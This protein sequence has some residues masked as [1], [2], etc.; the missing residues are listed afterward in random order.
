MSRFFK[1]FAI[2]SGYCVI[3]IF[4]VI[5]LA[6]T[7]SFF[8]INSEHCSQMIQEQ[9]N[10]RIPGTMVWKKLNISF[11]KGKLTIDG[12]QL[13]LDGKEIAGVDKLDIL[14][15]PSG[16]ARGEIVVEHF[17]IESPRAEIFISQDQKINILG[18]F[19]ESV[20]S[21]KEPQPESDVMKNIHFNVIV[22][23]LNIK[24]GR[25]TYHSE[26]DAVK[27]TL[28]NLAVTGKAN[29]FEKTA[30]ISISTGDI[31]FEQSGGVKSKLE[32]VAM[33]GHFLVDSISG[34][35]LV[36]DSEA[37]DIVIKGEATNLLPSD[38]ILSSENPPFSPD[39]DFTLDAN[40]VS[41]EIVRMLSLEHDIGGGISIHTEI[42]GSI[43]DP[44]LLCTIEYP[45][46]TL[47]GR[48]IE[49]F[50]FKGVMEKR[51]IVISS[52]EIDHPHAKL[53]ADGKVSLVKAF[54]QGFLGT[55]TG[56][57]ASTTPISAD[58]DK[59]PS[60][61]SVKEPSSSS[62]KHPSVKHPS[63]D[64]ADISWDFSIAGSDIEPGII[65][66]SEGIK[67]IGGKCGFTAK[68][69]GNMNNPEAHLDFQADGATYEGYPA[70]DT[71]L[72]V[73]LVDGVVNI[74]N[75]DISS[76]G[77]NVQ[78]KGSVAV[79]EKEQN[80]SFGKYVPM[81][82]PLLNLTAVPGEAFDISIILKELGRLGLLDEQNIE[83]KV[84]FKT[85]LK[86]TLDNLIAKVDL[87]A[88]NIKYEAEKIDKVDLKAE[89]R[90]KKLTIPSLDVT[91]AE[92]NNLNANG[93]LDENKR[94]NVVLASKG[95]DLL[96]I[97]AV[98]KTDMLKGVAICSVSASGTFD[99]PEING[100]IS[101]KSLEVMDKPFEDFTAY[102][103]LKNRKAR[104]AG[105]LNFDIDAF[106]DMD[107][108]D[109]SA[110][111]VFADTDLLPWF[112]F[113][114]VKDIEG[115][116]TGQI[117]VSGNADSP[118][119][120]TAR[121]NFDE[122]LVRHQKYENATINLKFLKAWSDGDS[123]EVEKFKILLPENGEVEISALGRIS[124]E[125]VADAKAVIPV[126]TAP[127]FVPDLPPMEG[128]L[129]MDVNGKMDLGSL[130]KGTQTV[131]SENS[132]SKNINEASLDL[133]GA[134]INANLQ[135]KEIAVTLPEDFGRVE[136]IN[137]TITGD[138]NRIDITKI[139][140]RFGTGTFLLKGG[141]ELDNYMPQNINIS[142]K[143]EAIPVNMVEGL[144]A[145]IFSDL[146]FNATFDKTVLSAALVSG[147]VMVANGLWNRDLSV[148]KEVFSTLTSRK[149][150]RKVA[151]EK[152]EPDPLLEKIALDVAVKGKT[153]FIVD[154]N[155]AYME[156]YPDI[157][158]MG[159]AASPA[160][161]GRSEIN[162]GTIN[163]QSSEFT[164]TKGIIDFVNP[165]VIEPELD[166][167]SHRSV[168]QWDVMLAVSGTPDNL[169]F[170]LS[171]DPQL[172][173]GD[174]IS[175]LLR[176]KTV[177]E[178]INAEGGT[179]MSTA[180]MLSQV[181]ASA[182]SDNL[183]AATGLDI[184]EVGFGNSTDDNGLSDMNVT[185]GKEITDNITIKYGAE[186][187]DGEMVHKTSAEYKLMDNVSV[188]GFQDS[189]GQFGG[190]VRYRLEFR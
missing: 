138:L 85:S 175:L 69:A 182:V 27:A 96:C 16:F 109:F 150:E 47:M 99:N 136:K 115:H 73:S 34:F 13:L 128:T 188:S 87:T 113:A 21:D 122:I 124:G 155:L 64:P 163:Y 144:A 14:L 137:G 153:P 1:R 20:E 149:R 112:N 71:K 180:G 33:E 8:Y 38:T 51:E 59:E 29:L 75:M 105:K 44:Y 170:K 186:T 168:R 164:L 52:L 5:A 2:I 19:P 18:A 70:V 61:S 83:G 66:D 67:G 72:K 15:V 76:C 127:L 176:G 157:K 24:N 9:V 60:S 106:F 102:I 179:T 146:K 169:D 129:I 88:E 45:D 171:S 94:F 39:L 135:F 4:V 32:K 145:D 166:I 12:F 142:F 63:I 120:V 80:G 26:A 7:S 140:G 25:F 174:I 81:A 40:I 86:G 151:K 132:E 189:A 58:M 114:G 82:S 123:F 100:N 156:I 11:F 104:I 91:L 134:S 68:L 74:G 139:K 35:S 173:D 184:F 181:A 126:S 121:C 55:E 93:W 103:S 111:A 187:K 37:A 131:G 162:P 158:V 118:D 148:E 42:R 41:E 159:N 3:F 177:S 49:K 36:V 95:I 10:S 78:I 17:N 79:L 119:K 22:N 77:A 185:M 48:K 98:R 43:N 57:K 108:R 183:K 130:K 28:D 117:K 190:E 6:I 110:E 84:E 92:N 167:E 161:S 125:V 172:E 62:V 56:N 30:D 152:K 160:V 178:L 101:L 90:D 143:T 116:T 53:K 23:S 147:E 50:S 54:P 46:G 97:D 154:N 65:L 165:Y 133:S 141:A 89:Y 107:S 31:S